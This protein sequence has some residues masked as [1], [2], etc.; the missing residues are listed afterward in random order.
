[1]NSSDNVGVVIRISLHYCCK[2]P[3]LD[4]N[5]KGC[6]GMMPLHV[7]AKYNSLGVVQILLTLGASLDAQDDDNQTPLHIAA[8][9]GNVDICMVRI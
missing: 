6:D 1:M 4:V 5:I 9:Q 2:R 8:K 3:L 7:A